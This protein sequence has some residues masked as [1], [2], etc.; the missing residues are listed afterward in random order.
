LCLRGLK[1]VELRVA[2][3][4]ASAL[5]LARALAGRMPVRYPGLPEHPAHALVLRQMTHCGPVLT[6]DLTTQERAERFCGR[7]ERIALATSFGG[8]E[9]TLERRARWGSDLVSPGLIR[10]SVG[11]EAPELLLEDIE[12]GLR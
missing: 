5:V 9:S 4:S 10:M 8:V 2:R 11:L 12:A 3:S 1:T 6:F 7:L